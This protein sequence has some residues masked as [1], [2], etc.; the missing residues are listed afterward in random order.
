MNTIE[1]LKELEVPGTP[2]FLFDCTLTSGDMQHWSTHSV[3]YNAQQYASRVLKHNAFD[4]KSSSEA[5]T[6]GTSNLSITL[7]NADSLLSSIERSIGWKGAQLVVT[8]VFFD[9]TNGVPVSDSQVVFRG[10]ANAPDQST[11]SG[12]RLSFMSRLNLQRV[13]LPDIQIQKRC[14]WAFPATDAQRQEAVSGGSQGQ[15]SPYYRCGYSAD[16]PGG[17]GTLNGSVPFTTCDYS[18]AQCQQR[19]MFDQDANNQITRRFGGI[20]FVPPSIIVRTYG[21]R[22]SHVSAPTQNQALY[23][24]FVPL[25]YGTG[26]YEPPIVFARNDG[27]LTHLEV[28]LGDGC[29]TGVL[30]VIVND[31][32]IPV[33]VSGSNMTGT[34]WYN[35]VRLGGRTGAFNLDFTDAAGNPLGDPY[36]SMGFLAVVVPNSISNGQSLPSIQVLIQGLQL[37]RYDTNGNYQDVVFTNNPAWVILDVL[38]RSGWNINEIDLAS[39]A[40][41]AQR[42]D[43]LVSTVDLNGNT[44]LVP[45]YQCNLLLTDRRSVGDIMR[46]IRNGSAM[47]AIF[48]T[49]GL[50]SLRPEDTLAIQQPSKPNGSNSTEPLNGGWPVYEFGDNTF[51]G[52]LRSGSGSVSL[53]VSSRNTANTPNQYTIEFQDQFNEYQ[54]DSL[55][56]V[57]VD[58]VVVAGQ[59]VS[60]T[61]TA[62]GLPNFD[63]ALR[64]ASLQLYKS[65]QGNTYVQFDTTVKG[66]DLKPGDIISLTYSKEGFNRQPFRITKLSPTA[67]FFTASITAQIHDDAWYAAVDAG[68]AGLGRQPPAEIGAPRPLVGGTFDATGNQQFGIMQTSQ[69][70]SDGTIIVDLSVTFSPPNQPVASAAGIPLLG[71]NPQIN[72][73]GGTLAGGQA[74]YYAISAIDQNGAEGGLSFTVMA[75]VPPGTNTNTVTLTSLSFSASAVSFHVYRGPNPVQLLRVAQYVAIATEFTDGGASALLVGPPDQNYDHAN[76]YWRLELQPEETVDIFSATIIGNSTLGMLPNEYSGATVRVTQGTGA[77]QE[78]IIANNSAT[79]ITTT[80]PW[81]V[82]PDASSCFLIADSTWQFGASSNGSPVSFSVPNREGVTVDISGR[83]ANVFDEESAYELSP[84]TSWRISGVTGDTQDSDVPGQANF[85]LAAIGQGNIE[86]SGISFVSLDNTRTINAGTLTLVYWDELTGPSNIL[87]SNNIGPTDAALMLTTEITAQTGALIQIDSEIAII[88][89]QAINSNSIQVSRGECG[90]NANAHLAQT[91]VYLLQQ[92]T[93]IMAFALEFFGS[94]ASGSY[95][96]SANLPDV[97]MALA[98]FFVTNSIG[99]S[100]V[101]TQLFTS[102]ND[103]GLRTLSGGQLLIQVEGPL[104]IQTNAA[105]PLLVE[106]PHSVRDVYAVVQQASLSGPIVMQVTQSGQAYCQLTIPAGATISNVV[107]GFALGPLQTQAEIGLDILSVVQA[108][109]TPAGSDLTVSIRL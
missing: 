101:S 90:T 50:L 45:R 82:N 58:D 103:A 20:E 65:V 15:F 49:S 18:R 107:D 34:G 16:Q 94:P 80:T 27:N 86:I 62:L 79:T 41:V 32:E 48:D 51:S 70:S 30:K 73:T 59:D 24:D 42:C 76:F 31:I 10:I 3:T 36:G 9:L 6:D 75:N 67:N 69:A 87:L 17:V 38:L 89:Q 98:E 12:L 11:E 35:V 99:N 2:L 61:L 14:P 7:A 74:L 22:G 47:Y 1:T 26:W 106:R 95:A 57:D 88:Q 63:Q 53:S 33:G 102:T 83:A 37:T 85:G 64:A 55:L 28:L 46:G 60:A 40:L 109:D 104:A 84:L 4:L 13:Y 77:G 97:R 54:Q 19:G 105:P 72:A 91:A 96:F 71:L 21:E 44:I 92:K 66:V 29:L 8:F 108:S 93:F 23:N 100:P 78:R 81:G 56:C 5:A 68:S 25:I 39:F 52:I 43:T